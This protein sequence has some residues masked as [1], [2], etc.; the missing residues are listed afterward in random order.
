MPHIRPDT[1]KRIVA[2]FSPSRDKNICVPVHQGR[3]GHPVLFGR[4]FF[5][6]LCALTGDEGGRGLMKAFGANI[7]EVTVDD[8]GI[9]EDFDTPE[10][11]GAAAVDD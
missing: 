3:R 6:A 5:Q 4:R 2:A 7:V 9:F 11:F 8:E 1:I 10:D